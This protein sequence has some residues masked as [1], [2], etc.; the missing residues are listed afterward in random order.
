[1]EYT[2]EELRQTIAE[3]QQL[4]D[5]QRELIEDQRRWIADLK[6]EPTPEQIQAEQDA[7]DI[8]LLT[9]FPVESLSHIALD[10]QTDLRIA[11]RIAREE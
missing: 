11:A 6:H 10:K 7:A 8:A 3:K 5:V 1:M 4:I 9:S 2:R